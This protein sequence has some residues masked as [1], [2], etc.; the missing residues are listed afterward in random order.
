ML[1]LSPFSPAQFTGDH[2]LET[3]SW[4][5][6]DGRTWN[7]NVQVSKIFKAGCL[8]QYYVLQKANAFYESFCLVKIPDSLKILSKWEK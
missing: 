4:Q 8:C 1:S 6:H 7:P 5:P 2:F 3:S